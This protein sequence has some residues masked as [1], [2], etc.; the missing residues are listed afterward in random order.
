MLRS[1]FNLQVNAYLL[2]N[3]FMNK[4]ESESVRRWLAGWQ[5][6]A[7]VLEQLRTEAI[8]RSNSAMAIEQLS[9]AFES[10]LRHCPPT[11]TSGLV[12]QQRL[13]ARWRR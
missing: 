10:A 5:R 8:R 9:D 6:A 3:E 11:A 13:F 1:K 2:Y 4:T 12:E 7:P